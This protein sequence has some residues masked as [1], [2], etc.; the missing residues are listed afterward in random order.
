MT[1]DVR[2]NPG[3]VQV[4]HIVTLEILNVITAA[5]NDTTMDLTQNKFYNSIFNEGEDRNPAFY[6]FAKCKDTFRVYVNNFLHI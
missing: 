4:F 2:Q 6:D 3:S 1:N 5:N